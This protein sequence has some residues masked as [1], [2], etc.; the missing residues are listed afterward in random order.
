MKILVLGGTGMVGSHFMNR[1]REE[2]AEVWGTL[3]HENRQHA[4][5]ASGK[6]VQGAGSGG[7]RTEEGKNAS[8]GNRIYRRVRGRRH[9]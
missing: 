8:Q 1:Y 4:A 6:A 3:Q 7:G 9:Q 2:G 5:G